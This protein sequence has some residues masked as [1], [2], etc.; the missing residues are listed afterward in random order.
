MTYLDHIK[1]DPLTDYYLVITGL[2]YNKEL[3]A[4]EINVRFKLRAV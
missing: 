4:A 3:T 1:L 2:V